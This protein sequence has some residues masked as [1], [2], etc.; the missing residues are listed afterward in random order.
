MA[1][2]ENAK[3]KK[4]RSFTAAALVFG[5]IA[6]AIVILLNL[7]V[8]KLN[9]TWDM[10]P[11]SIYELTQPTKDYLN[12]VDKK[13]NMYF[14]F[15][16][17]VLST[18]T[19]SMPLYH[20]LKEYSGFS[21]IN[22]EA[23]DPESKPEKTKE[24]QN[25]GYSLSEGDIV[26]ECEGK[27]K[28]IPANTMFETHTDRSSDG[29]ASTTTMYFTGENMITGAIQAVVT[30]KETK[31]YF[32]TGHSEKT[33]DMDYSILKKNLSARNYI[34][35]TLD[36]TSSTAVPEDAA[37]VI[38]A[39]PKTDI[40]DNEL[41]VLNTYLDNGGNI[42]FW[43]SPNEDEVDYTNIESILKDYSIG[44]DYDIVEEKD[45]DFHVPYDFRSF[46]CSIV[47]AEQTDSIDLTSGLAD[48]VDQGALPVMI[49]S[50]SFAQIYNEGNGMENVTTGSL[51]QTIDRLGDGSSKAVGVPMGGAKPREEITNS[52]LDLAMFATDRN[53]MNS[54]IMVMGNGEFIDDENIYQAY[55]VISVNLQLT[56]F[57][58]MYDSDEA[59]DFGISGKERTFDEMHIESQNK[60]KVT[61]VIFIAVPVVVGLIGGIVWL[62]RRYSE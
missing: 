34:A 12:S 28:H 32:L 41:A 44:L 21:C 36:L 15:D 30:G 58:W 60:A 8:S 19:D 42:C 47:K 17:D 25:M 20:A 5:A 48:F 31:V 27:S 59:L 23:F 43:M 3:P 29:K 62:R 16:M 1:Q 9:V 55:N 37:I 35:E 49:N 53:R 14:L 54:K 6:L 56:V 18:D 38:V 10:T 2:N 13:I 22:F 45:E 24:L 57:S 39:A 61:T 4:A 33:V 11:T 50:R 40:S 52:V 46:R 51:L 7:M 26:V